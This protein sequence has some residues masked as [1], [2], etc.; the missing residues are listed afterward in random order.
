MGMFYTATTLTLL[1]NALALDISFND[2]YS[3][4]YNSVIRK[5]DDEII[6]PDKEDCNGVYLEKT[7]SD[8]INVYSSLFT[9]MVEQLSFASENLNIIRTNEFRRLE[10]VLIKLAESVRIVNTAETYLKI[11]AGLKD[12]GELSEVE[13]KTLVSKLK[14]VEYQT[15]AHA[16]SDYKS[17]VTNSLSL[18]FNSLMAETTLVPT[19]MKYSSILHNVGIIFDQRLFGLSMLPDQIISAQT[20]ILSKLAVSVQT[21]LLPALSANKDMIAQSLADVSEKTKSTVTETISESQA[22]LIASQTEIVTT[23]TTSLSNEIQTLG[24]TLG[25]TLPTD[26]NVGVYLPE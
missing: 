4:M 22:E 21:P 9:T 20:V 10:S 16:L 24:A 19:T 26:L 18:Y 3:Q 14:K 11:E 5:C 23:M 1:S 8:T 25:L 13:I 12:L 7:N 15:A 2:A 6:I 17:Q